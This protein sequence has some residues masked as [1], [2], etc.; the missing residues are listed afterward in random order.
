MQPTERIRLATTTGESR[1][2][3]VQFES[4]A[5][6]AAWLEPSRETA[7]K[8]H[9]E[10]AGSEFDFGPPSQVLETAGN[11]EDARTRRRNSHS[12][13]TGREGHAVQSAGAEAERPNQEPQATG[14]CLGKR[15]LIYG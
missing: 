6:R 3:T 7:A 14:P 10:E 2:G 12:K 13:G 5:G 8:N 1:V 4:A 9:E 15:E 11:V